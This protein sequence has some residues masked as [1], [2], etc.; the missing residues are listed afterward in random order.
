MVPT[1][2]IHEVCA[3]RVPDDIRNGRIVAVAGRVAAGLADNEHRKLAKQTTVRTLCRF[4]G[5][6][7]DCR[8]SRSNLA[9]FPSCGRRTPRS[10]SI[11]CPRGTWHRSCISPPR[12]ARTVASATRR[13]SSVA[14]TEVPSFGQ[15]RLNVIFEAGM[16]MARDRDRVV[17]VEVGATRALRDTAGLNV[18]R[19]DD[20]LEA[21]KD[22]A[23]RLRAATWMS[24]SAGRNGAASG[25]SRER[26]SP[27]ETS[28]TPEWTQA[29]ASTTAD[30]WYCGTSRSTSG[31]EAHG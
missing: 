16:A 27:P 11:V 22:L 3:D 28:T 9:S 31:P 17:I 12:R 13:S 14:L 4:T 6:P 7:V 18:V 1:Q 24:T 19:L 20:G 8:H 26:P 23:G 15:A 2:V 10:S 5:G 21:R 30:N 29:T 25:R